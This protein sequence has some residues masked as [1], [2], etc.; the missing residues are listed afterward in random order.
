MKKQR[1]ITKEDY[2]L[3]LQRIYGKIALDSPSFEELENYYARHE[4][5]FAPC[6]VDLVD[7]VV[8]AERLGRLDFPNE[9]IRQEPLRS[10]L[11]VNDIDNQL[12]REGYAHLTL[13]GKPL[14]EYSLR[15]FVDTKVS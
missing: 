1:E 7:V 8:A 14:G 3:S 5:W 13:C 6:G 11:D 10:R 15:E 4:V 12:S 2:F 9:D